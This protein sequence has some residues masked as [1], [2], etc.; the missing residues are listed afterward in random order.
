MLN[1]R[2]S[3]LIGAAYRDWTWGSAL[4]LKTL[5][6]TRVNTEN[7]KAQLITTKN[8]VRTQDEIHLPLQSLR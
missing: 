3:G 6:E 8:G 7:L 4:K 2:A 1:T 5:L